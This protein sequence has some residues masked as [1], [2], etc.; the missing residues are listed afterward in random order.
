[1]KK[2]LIIIVLLVGSIAMLSS[3]NSNQ[4]SF[5]DGW[6]DGYQEAL[7]GCMKVGIT[8]ICPIA[9]V[10]KDTYQHGFGMGY[11]KATIKCEE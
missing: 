5:C 7:D 3:F 10:G 6:D 9:P 1:M 11:A 8:P 2:L 4:S